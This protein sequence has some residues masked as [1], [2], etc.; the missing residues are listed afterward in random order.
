MENP[1]DSEVSRMVCIAIVAR[2]DL[3]NQ[4]AMRSIPYFF[5]GFKNMVL[6]IYVVTVFG[7]LRNTVKQIQILFLCM[8]L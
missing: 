6:H 1:Q 5:R 4:S 3:T 8:S 2:L 7:L